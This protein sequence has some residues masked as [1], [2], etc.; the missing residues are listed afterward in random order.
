[1]STQT[2]PNRERRNL[3]RLKGIQVTAVVEL[4]RT[5]IPLKQARQLRVGQVVCSEKH[6]G[7]LLDLRINGVKFAEGEI[8]LVYEPRHM[9]ISRLTD[10]SVD[11]TGGSEL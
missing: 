8:A 3:E 10:P 6:A 5:E 11:S 9:R 1:M 7:Q 4:F 2:Q